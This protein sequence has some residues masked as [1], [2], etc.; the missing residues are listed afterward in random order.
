VHHSTILTEKP[1]K[2]QQCIKILFHI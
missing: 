2:K 1:N